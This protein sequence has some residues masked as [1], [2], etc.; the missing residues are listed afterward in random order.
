MPNLKPPVTTV[1]AAGRYRDRI[2]AALPP[3]TS[4]EPLMT[5]YLTE[6]TEAAEIDRAAASGFV[7][8]VKCYPAGSTTHSDAGVTSL[9]RC[10]AVLERME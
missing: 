2:R 5:L 9:A 6:T 8:G 10:E 7:H 1:S 4:F 3:G